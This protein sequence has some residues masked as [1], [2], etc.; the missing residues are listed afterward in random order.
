[1]HRT[2]NHGEEW[3]EYLSQRPLNEH[4]RLVVLGR[5]GAT[6]ATNTN[7]SS[8]STVNQR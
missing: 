1:M 5:S 3:F 4:Q 8:M 6:I 2:A 7:I